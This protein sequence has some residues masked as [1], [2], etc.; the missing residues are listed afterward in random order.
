MRP[1]L[2]TVKK[3]WPASMHWRS[4]GLVVLALA[5]GGCSTLR[6]NPVRYETTEAI[7]QAIDLKA[8]EVA[9]LAD[10]PS[11]EERN[12]IQ[13]KAMAVID[14]RFNSFARELAADRADSSTA[15]AGTT[16]GA[17]TA[18]AFVES[19]KA[20]TN[21]ALFAAGVVGAFGIVDKNYFYEKT[22]P[23]LVAGMRAARAT[24]LLRIRQG[25]GETLESYDGVA[26]LQ[27]LEDYYAAGTLLASIAEIT[28]RAEADT[29][30]VLAQVRELDVPTP[31][32]IDNRRKI[33]QAIFAIKDQSGVD[34]GNQALT[35][36]GL[37]PQ[38]TPKDTRA[39]LV[40]ALQ[41]RTPER[42]AIV[43]KA[44]KDAGLLK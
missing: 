8:D 35:S 24:V 37:L 21:Y 25:Q 41:P 6:G 20:K 34:K 36:L 1:L 19:V 15:V 27:D 23:A 10:P 12:R 43:E 11:R 31:A 40:K 30:A 2:S 4:T 3:T 26:A 28:A 18:G 13:N 9:T 16:L 39:A 29:V 38:T 44:L 42:I 7:V 32:Q 14:L 22:V 17:S 33:S 5:T